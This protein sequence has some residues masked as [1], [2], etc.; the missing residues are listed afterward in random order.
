MKWEFPSDFFLIDENM[1][2]VEKVDNGTNSLKKCP[3][4]EKSIYT[5][6]WYIP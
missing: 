6:G 3:V 2:K 1:K 4:Q 5:S